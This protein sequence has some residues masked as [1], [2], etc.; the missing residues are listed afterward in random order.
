MEAKKNVSRR[1]SMWLKKYIY[2]EEKIYTKVQPQPQSST[3]S[4]VEE[5]F[6]KKKRFFIFRFDVMSRLEA[7]TMKRNRITVKLKV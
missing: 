7:P 6:K 2:I 5:I 1:K 3:R 4:A